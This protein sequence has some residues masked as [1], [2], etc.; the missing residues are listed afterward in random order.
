VHPR[1]GSSILAVLLAMVPPAAGAVQ[2]VEALR[3]EAIAIRRTASPITVDGDLSDPAW[4]EAARVAV[5][6]ETNPGDNLEP[7]VENV[8]WLAYDERFFYA[9]FE[10]ADPEPA[11]IRAAYADRDNLP[12]DTDYGGVILD[13]RNDGKTA[14]MFLA[15]P[16][17]IQYDALSSDVSGEDSSPDFFWDSAA[18][19]TPRGWTLELRIPFSS[20]R[21]EG[22][23]AQTW[24]VLLYRNYPRDYR[25]Q[26]FSARLPRGG[27][28]FI[29]RANGL[30]GLEG[31]PSGGHLVVAPFST[32]GQQSRPRGDVGTPL[33]SGDM[34][35]EIG[36]DAKWNPNADTTLDL[37][38]NP[39]FSQVESDVAQI[40]ANERFAL[41]FPEKR[42]F[43]LEGIDLFSTTLQALNTRTITSPRWG[44]RATGTRGD[45]AYTLLVADDRGGGSVILPG[46][47][48]SDLA[49]QDFASRVLVTRVRHDLGRSYVSLLGSAREI[50]GGGYNRVLGPDFQWR[51]TE[52]DTVTGQI[53]F[54]R[55]ETPE[56]PDLA[57]EWD[58]RNLAGHAAQL[59][60]AHSTRTADWTVFY[61]DRGDEFRA[62]NG[63]VAQV[64]IRDLY[65]EVGYT[66]RPQGFLRRLRTFAVVDRTEDRDGEL[67]F[68]QVYPGVGMDGK[69]NSFLRFWYAWEEVRSGGRRLPR[70]RLNF[71]LE[72]SPNRAVSGLLL[73]GWVGEEIDFAHSRVGDG[74][75]L[76]AAG[77]LRPT[78]HLELRLDASRR[79]L[80]VD[81]PGSGGGRLFTAQVAR[82]RATYTFSARSYLRAIVQRVATER[83]PELFA[84]PEVAPEDEFVSGSL[85]FAYKLNWQ[86]VL[87]VGAGEDRELV[88]VGAGEQLEPSGRQLFLKLSYAFQR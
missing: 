68:S 37:A 42:P 1:S 65:G 38:L 75:N 47:D 81:P 51:P 35:S 27:N 10:F 29:C 48:S 3:G 55:S 80:D 67:V 87:F 33:E 25:Y 77:T 39:D 85:L 50:E 8:G 5:W 41:F 53:L 76:V 6:Y 15:N 61:S 72:A 20:L 79:W 62:D 36:L 32:A 59:W 14:Q 84:D 2:G 73:E 63:F 30:T 7:K 13:T 88:A 9:A 69:W 82:L 58:G 83:D 43:F 21:H 57:A 34:E 19:I 52:S 40:A 18:R 66:V 64:G 16:R 74:A 54:S 31:L 4:R 23:G 46:P 86:T 56:R 71:I 45:T 60:W 11:R 49:E 28:C 44:G 78:D 12:G 70:R 22:S 24:G 17:G 26:H